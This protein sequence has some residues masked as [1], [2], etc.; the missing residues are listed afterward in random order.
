[1]YMNERTPHINRLTVSDSI[2]QSCR[3]YTQKDQ[4][5]AFRWAIQALRKAW[6][7]RYLNPDEEHYLDAI[8]RLQGGKKKRKKK[9]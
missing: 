7:D 6:P 4:D 3:A 2:I 1:M 8:I 5:A 9:K